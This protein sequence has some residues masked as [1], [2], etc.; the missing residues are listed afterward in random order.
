MMDRLIT[1][2][3]E[4]LNGN[5]TYNSAP[6]PVYTEDAPADR[7]SHYIILRAEGGTD[8]SNNNRF[9][10]NAVVVIDIVTVHR[11]N[12]K[13][14]I[15]DDIDRQIFNLVLPTANVNVLPWQDGIQIV[16]VKRDTTAYLY[17]DDGATDKYYTKASRYNHKIIIR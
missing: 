8:D 17:E 6:I 1:A 2:W 5:I 15:A 10:E 7:Q 4:L 3:Y 16:N 9:E 13:R 12:V 14:S 11:N